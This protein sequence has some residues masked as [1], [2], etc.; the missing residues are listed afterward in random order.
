MLLSDG[1]ATPEG[2]T[3]DESTIQV[4]LGDPALDGEAITV[5][6][7]VTAA[8]A[9]DVDENTLR[10]ELAGMTAD[11]AEAALAEIGP[12]TVELW[13]G[14]VDRVPRLGWRVTFDV[15]AEDASS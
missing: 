6:A 7:S 3:L 14:W 13:P 15:Q 4:D 8:A 1:R 2:A 9:R 10:T 5:P 11:D 12:S